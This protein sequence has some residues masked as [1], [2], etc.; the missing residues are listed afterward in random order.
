MSFLPDVQNV[1]IDPPKLTHLLTH[2]SKARFFTLHGFDPSRPHELDAALRKHPTQNRVESV[3]QS[4]NG[5]KFTIRC[6]MPSPDGR[7]PCA[8]TVWIIA[9]GQSR[10][11]FVTGYASPIAASGFVLP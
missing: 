9:T 3:I 7:N 5:E 4:P 1:Y 8:L 2:P 10:A 6:S 11:R